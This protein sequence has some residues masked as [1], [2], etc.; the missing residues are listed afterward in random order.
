MTN[1]VFLQQKSRAH[2]IVRLCHAT[3][4]FPAKLFYLVRQVLLLSDSSYFKVLECTQN[5]LWR[6]EIERYCEVQW[7]TT[8]PGM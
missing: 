5:L 6:S 7:L 2:C 1:V 8:I 3:G 4:Q